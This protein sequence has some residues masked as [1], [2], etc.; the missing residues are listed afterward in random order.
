LE[1]MYEY[2]LRYEVDTK[3]V[4][5]IIIIRVLRILKWCRYFLLI[6]QEKDALIL[7]SIQERV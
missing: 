1:I 6:E 4:G 5:E 2:Y 7:K 3:K